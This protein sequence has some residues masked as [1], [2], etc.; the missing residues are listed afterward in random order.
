MKFAWY[1]CEDKNQG[2]GDGYHKDI[3]SFD[4]VFKE[5]FGVLIEKHYSNTEAIPEEDVEIIGSAP[6]GSKTAWTDK[7][8]TKKDIKNHVLKN[9]W[10][11]F[12][13]QYKNKDEKDKYIQGWSDIS[14]M[15][16]L[17][18]EQEQLKKDYQKE[19][20][21]EANRTGR[22]E[23]LHCLAGWDFEAEPKVK[24]KKS[25]DKKCKG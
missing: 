12:R 3:T 25:N 2:Y 1:S 6:F 15:P 24:G 7:I 4:Q 14:T 16:Y 13:I 22:K 17:N 23:V 10:C 19:V 11:Q 20:Q 8:L 18:K 5:A 9:G 21:K